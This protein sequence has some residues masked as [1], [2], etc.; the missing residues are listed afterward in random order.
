MLTQH[1]RAFKEWAVACEAMKGGA[2]ILLI[3]KGGIRECDDV[4]REF[5]LSRFVLKVVPGLF[6]LEE[7]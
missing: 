7:R 2:Q 4:L 3:R 1:N 6:E 5:G